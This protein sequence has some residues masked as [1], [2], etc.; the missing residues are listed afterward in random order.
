M[1]LWTESYNTNF[2]FRNI[3]KDMTEWDVNMMHSRDAPFKSEWMA[4]ITAALLYQ[5]YLCL[6][7]ENPLLHTVRKINI[8]INMVIT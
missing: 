2:S 5:S 6:V 3:A 8:I 7:S 1:S 4:W